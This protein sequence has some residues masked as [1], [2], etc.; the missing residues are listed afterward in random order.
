MSIPM[1]SHPAEFLVNG[2]LANEK[3]FE[4]KPKTAMK[5]PGSAIEGSLRSA[6][7]KGIYLRLLTPG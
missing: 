2:V 4:E 7:G 1:G 5:L 3:G 6:G